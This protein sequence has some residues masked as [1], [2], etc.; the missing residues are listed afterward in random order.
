[1]GR[2]ILLVMRHF[3]GVTDLK[4]LTIL[5]ILSSIAIAYLT[6]DTYA[7]VTPGE[8]LA[9]LA[10]VFVLFS[11]SVVGLGIFFVDEESQEANKHSFMNPQDIPCCDL[12]LN[13]LGA[14][15]CPDCG[16][17]WF[18]R[19]VVIDDRELLTCSEAM[20]QRVFWMDEWEII[21]GC[22]WIQDTVSIHHRKD[23]EYY[24]DTDGKLLFHRTTTGEIVRLAVKQLIFLSILV[25]VLFYFL[26]R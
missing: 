21:S 24:F 14:H 8:A 19:R 3:F 2:L 5:L 12:K 1:M 23:G 11:F 4:G 15:E 20:Q 13:I 25:C 18:L 10:Y 17:S 6:S 26:L 7:L 22:G 16:Y 9:H